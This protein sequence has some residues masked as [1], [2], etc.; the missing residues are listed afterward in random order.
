MA[1]L[2][3]AQSAAQPDVPLSQIGAP[4]HELWVSTD[5]EIFVRY[6]EPKRLRAGAMHLSVKRY[7]REAIGDWRHLQSIKN[8]IAGWEREA[9]ELYPAESRLVDEANQTHLWVLGAGLLLPIGFHEGRVVSTQEEGRDRYPGA[10]KAR[11][12]PW[13][14]GLSTG[15]GYQPS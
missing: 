8:E 10:E 3:A 14:P 11:Q 7:D 4:L 15:P 9:V 6:L 12:R 5:Y 1:K 2:R 13:E